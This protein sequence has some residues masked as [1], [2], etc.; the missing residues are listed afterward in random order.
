[1]KIGFSQMKLAENYQNNVNIYLSEFASKIDF[2]FS[3]FLRL[4][5]ISRITQGAKPFQKGKGKPKQD[6]KIMQEKPYVKNFKMDETFRPLLRGS[7]INRYVITWN[8]DYY[9]S[10]GGWLAEPRYSANYDAQIKIVIRQTG[11]SLMATIDDRQ[12][13]VRDNLYTITSTK[14][15]YS[16]YII[17]ALLNSRLL[18]WYYQN[19]VN[20]EVGEALAQVKR[21]HLEVLPMPNYS[22]TIFEKTE[23]LVKKILDLKKSDNYAD[24]T[25]LENQID[26]LVYMLYELSMEEIKVIEEA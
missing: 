8:H 26:K 18:N 11:S 25:D 3:T 14:N 22:Q 2:K 17:L 5:N 21:G 16:E 15:E 19:V 4:D 7:L 24:T 12:F 23:L 20:N 13:V 6:E 10:L 9:I 1:M